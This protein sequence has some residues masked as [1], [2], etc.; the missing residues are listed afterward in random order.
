M[1][2]T[3]NDAR[4]LISRSVRSGLEFESWMDGSFTDFL[5]EFGR[6]ADWGSAEKELRVAYLQ[7]VSEKT[8]AEFE[9]HGADV[10]SQFFR[11]LISR[12]SLERTDAQLAAIKAETRSPGTSGEYL[13]LVVY[14]AYEAEI[15]RQ[16]LNPSAIPE[17][18]AADIAVSQGLGL[19]LID[20]QA[21]VVAAKETLIC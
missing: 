16:R 9:N 20:V 4:L 7:L 13:Q 12:V 11:P 3:E 5:E 17:S 10:T 8:E 6:L 19:S 1:Y 21:S 15:M 2:K 18:L 14:A